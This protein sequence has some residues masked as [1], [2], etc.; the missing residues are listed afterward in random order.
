MTLPRKTRIQ[1]VGRY[2]AELRAQHEEE[3]RQ[4]ERDLH[5]Q[6]RVFVRRSARD[7]GAP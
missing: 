6:W 5:R 4:L 7:R 3:L 1:L 2:E